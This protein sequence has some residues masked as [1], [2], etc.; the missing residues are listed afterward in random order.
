[1]RLALICAAAITLAAAVSAGEPSGTAGSG[2]ITV[3]SSDT[4]LRSHLVFK[5]PV[6]I[7]KDGQL[8]PAPDPSPKAAGPMADFQSPLPSADWIKPDFNDSSWEKDRAPIE[9]GPEVDAVRYTGPSNSLICVRAKFTVADPGKVQDLKLSLEYVGGAVVHVNG[10]ELSR[11]HMPSG[12]IKPDT[13]AEKYPDDLYVQPDGN[14]AQIRAY[15][16]SPEAQAAFAPRFRKMA[17]VAV[18]QKLLRAG[19]NVLAIEVHRAP[20]NE[21]ATTAR[22]VKQDT[23]SGGIPGIWAYAGL[24][25]LSLTA[26]AGSALSPNVERPKGI[27]VWN[28]APY[29]T[30][31]AFSYGDGGELQPIVVSSPRNGVFSGRLAVSSDQPI[32]GLKAAVSELAGPGGAKLP[33]AS[34]RV[35]WAEAGIASGQ[36]TSSVRHNALLE[37]APAE[38]PVV[39]AAHSGDQYPTNYLR[40]KYNPGPCF[41]VKRTGLAGGAVA[42]LWITVRVPRETAAGSYQGTVTVSADGLP[43]VVVPFRV[44]VSAWTMPDPK[45]FHVTSFGQHSPD[46]LA[47]YYNVPMW[48][49][50]HFDLMGK[51][52]ALMAEVNSRQ[53]LAELAID[54]YGIGGNRESMVRW[55]KDGDGYKHDFAVL[56][57]YLDMVAK[58]MGKPA[59]LRLN[60]WGEQRPGWGGMPADPAECWAKVKEGKQVSLLDPATGKIE[61]MDQPPPGTEESLKFWKPVL[62]EVRK[63]VEARGWFDVTAMGHNSYNC[64]A[65][66][67]AVSI[68][69][70]IWP[71]GVWAYTAHNGEL[72]AKWA[73]T[74]KG[75]TV[76]ARYADCVWTR[77]HPTARGYRALLGPRPG[78]W[79]YTFR[80]DF[81]DTSPLV[82]YRDIL[83]EEIMCGHDGVSDFGV[84]FFAFK[85]K[86]GKLTHVGCGRG[87]GGPTCTCMA[88]LA[89]GPDGPVASER[90]EQFREGLEVAEAILYLERALQE[91][92]VGGELAGKVNRLL[93]ARGEAFMKHWPNGRFERDLELLALAGEVAAA[94]GGGK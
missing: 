68:F 21:A 75:V 65:Y 38:V 82:L 3:L 17:G 30:V 51:S 49:D 53:A 6:V 4:L 33:A 79:C 2:T 19:V 67:A 56:D 52:L 84:D 29:E 58:S 78:F 91:K 23:G 5:T 72:G 10:Q 37:A 44:E 63:R 25:D 94:A 45:D 43:P 64:P 8:K 71:D 39:R 86:S 26:A 14:F 31:S 76:L 70:K 77:G 22:R 27:Q 46:S 59:L 48:S 35:R 89:A 66:P 62:D 69:R 54:F 93:D 36:T 88:I 55:I 1:M 20:V 42:P 12:E 81:N 34:V 28:C 90:Y 15:K 74:E 60:C 61:P 32:R 92:K 7:G 24:K 87:T 41:P 85:S 11:G 57:K 80:T 18:P 9:A 16:W 47:L 40:L 83:E 13:L 73:T 50:R